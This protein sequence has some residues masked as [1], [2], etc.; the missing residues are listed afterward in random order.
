LE[1]YI[2]GQRYINGR[3]REMQRGKKTNT[4]A[5]LSS[6][7]VGDFLFAAELVNYTV[8]RNVLPMQAMMGCGEWEL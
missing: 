6:S 3:K 4:N 1:Q 8:V 2:E 5:R 7:N